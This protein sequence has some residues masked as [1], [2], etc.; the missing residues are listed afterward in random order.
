MLLESGTLPNGANLEAE[1]VIVGAGP[2][3]IATGLTLARMGRQVVLVESGNRLPVPET[4]RLAEATS[5]DQPYTPYFKQ[6]LR[7]LGG[8]SYR[9]QRDPAWQGWGGYCASLDTHDL[10]ARPWM[11][12][13]D[14]PLTLEEDLRPFYSEAAAYCSLQ[15]LDA[16]VEDLSK[17]LGLETI[18]F[19]DAAFVNKAMRIAPYPQS[20]FGTA[21][22]EE[23]ETA[24]NLRV[25]LGTTVRDIHVKSGRVLHVDGIDGNGAE[26]RLRGQAFVLAM[27]GIDNARAL[28]LTH[29]SGGEPPDRTG[30]YFMEHPHIVI[31]ILRETRD[32]DLDFYSETMWDAA[33]GKRCGMIGV[34]G[35]SYQLQ[36][37]QGIGNFK[38]FIEPAACVS[39]PNERQR[40]DARMGDY[41]VTMCA[42]QAPSAY[43]RVSLSNARDSMSVP[44][45]HLSW[46]LSPVDRH[47]IMRGS[48]AF[49]DALAE[50]GSFDI[51]PT[52]K[53]ESWPKAVFGAHHHMGTTRMD[54]DASNGVVDANCKVHGI[55]NTFVAGCSV[56]PSG[57]EAPPTFTLVALAVRLGCHL[58]EVLP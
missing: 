6:R 34:V 40:L 38:C 55:D 42:E 54:A 26:I 20:F 25:L 35:P 51:Q 8:T 24:P 23:L 7:C 4:Q 1:V 49:L 9:S 48:A 10:Q 3:G 50:L 47:T 30:W 11:G 2:A 46:Q 14:W 53:D 58:A 39:I 29:A 12:Q 37:N 41:V 16:S 32:V 13:V 22:S 43:N 57:G 36:R 45:P 52:L 5:D 21:H 28:L 56:F 33:N 27:G 18:Q 15:D 19:A 44:R 17:L 31:A